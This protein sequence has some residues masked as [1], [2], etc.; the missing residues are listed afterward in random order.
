MDCPKTECGSIF[1]HDTTKKFITA[2]LFQ[3]KIKTGNFFIPNYDYIYVS[4]YESTL[5]PFYEN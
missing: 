1:F 4:F 5:K 3:R 2:G